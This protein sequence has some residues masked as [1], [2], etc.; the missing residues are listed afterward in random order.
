MLCYDCY[1][2]YQFSQSERTFSE[3]LLYCVILEEEI[4]GR[5]VRGAAIRITKTFSLFS[6]T[7]ETTPLDRVSRNPL[8]SITIRAPRLPLIFAILDLLH[9][10]ERFWSASTGRVTTVVR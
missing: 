10:K 1:A 7:S 3:A 8:L 9:G 6:L 4:A 2:V 5:G